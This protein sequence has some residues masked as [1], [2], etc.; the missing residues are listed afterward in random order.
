MPLEDE[1]H[2]VLVNSNGSDLLDPDGRIMTMPKLDAHVQGKRHRAVSV[3]IFSSRGEVM[4]QK[5]AA[6]KYHSAGLWSNT[7][8]THPKPYEI[9]AD[10]ARLRLVEEMNMSCSLEEIFT[11]TYQADVGNQLI[12]NEFDHVFFGFTDTHPVINPDEAADWRWHPI[13]NL[14]RD[15]A[16]SPEQYAPWLRYCFPTV[17]EEYN[18]RRSQ[19]TRNSAATNLKRD[20]FVHFYSMAIP[21]SNKIK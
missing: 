20:I 4:L 16:S 15:M 21:Q 7:C 17:M 12:E 19:I 2:V 8:C 13:N 18:K 1:E 9:P 10:T 11:F 5:R 14:G 3:F 6:N